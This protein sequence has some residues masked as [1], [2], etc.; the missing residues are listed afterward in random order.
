MVKSALRI[1]RRFAPLLAGLSIGVV[2]GVA[3]LL[4][5]ETLPAYVKNYELTLAA[6]RA[7]QLA[8]TNWRSND[9]VEDAVYQKA[10]DLGVSLERTQI[11]V[12]SAVTESK[13][14]TLDTLVDPEE[15]PT[16]HANV[17]IEASYIVPIELPG[18]TLHLQLHFHA[19]EHSG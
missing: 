4:F 12:A 5:V 14:S 15:H 13:V 9:A 16:L 2:A 11:N 1:L 10:Q 6:E 17:D 18:Y 7:A 8:S 19:S 3:I